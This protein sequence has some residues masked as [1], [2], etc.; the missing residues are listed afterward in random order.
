MRTKLRNFSNVFCS[1]S[2]S[3]LQFNLGRASLP[4]LFFLGLTTVASFAQSALSFSRITKVV[5][6]A[7]IQA[8]PNHHPLWASEATDAGLLPLEQALNQFTMVLARSPQQEQALGQLIADQQDPASPNY[9]HWLTPTEIG[10]RFGLS[11]S[12]ITTLTSWLQSQGLH[13]NWISPSRTFIGFGGAAADVGRAFQTEMHTYKVNGEDRISV[14]S[15][16]MIPEALA[17]AIQSI[18]GLFT[19][20]EHPFYRAE[21]AR[22]ASPEANSSSGNHYL[23]PADFATLYDLPASLT[24]AGTTIGIVDRSRTNFADFTNFSAL[25]GSTFPNPTEIVPTAFGGVDPG[26]AYTAPPGGTTSTGEQGEATLDVLR[27]GSV[28]PGANLLLVV[29]TSAS[30]GIDADTE[31]LVNTSPVPAQVI[32]ISFGAC[33]SSA[34]SGSVNFWNTLF[35]QGAAEGISTFVSSGDSGASG[36]DTHGSA[37]PSSPLANSPNYICSSS[38]ATCVGGTEFNDASNTSQYWSASQGAGLKSVLSY[39]PEGGWNEST[40]S[41]VAASGGGVSSIVATPSWQY[42]LACQQ[43]GPGATHPTF[44]SP[45][46]VTTATSAALP[47]EDQVVSSQMVATLS[48]IFMALPPLLPTWPAS[49]RCSTRSWDP[50][51]ETSIQ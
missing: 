32:T 17:P 19:I 51:K 3:C 14:A 7:R 50:R 22:S 31:Y 24:G 15:D 44:R 20:E 12:D 39:I 36:C 25:T 23:A 11:D 5:D 28:A 30:G 2:L 49:R 34:G 18:R 27:A 45:A 8:L 47:P 6:P 43:R 9:H 35:Q 4:A 13:V 21:S 46:P 42:A 38:Y 10:D 37:P 26:P 48:N 41:N 1:E 29:A 33:E 40:T 16:P